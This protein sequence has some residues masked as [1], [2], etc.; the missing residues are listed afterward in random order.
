MDMVLVNIKHMTTF[1]NLSTIACDAVDTRKHILSKKIRKQN[2]LIAGEMKKDKCF[3]FLLM[4]RKTQ[5][6]Q[7]IQDSMSRSHSLYS[8]Q[9]FRQSD[10]PEKE[11]SEQIMNVS[12]LKENKEKLWT[13]LRMKTSKSAFEQLQC[14]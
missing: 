13:F 6:R 2:M 11:K 7:Q 3:E 1:V 12:R 10:F 8:G 14:N 9:K 5:L 4:F